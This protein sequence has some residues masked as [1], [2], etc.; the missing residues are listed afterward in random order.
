M[1]NLATLRPEDIV[2]S[3]ASLGD[4]FPFAVLLWSLGANTW[5]IADRLNRSEAVIHNALPEIR[6]AAREIKAGRK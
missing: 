2:W 6:K 3:N 5:E 4:D 1:S